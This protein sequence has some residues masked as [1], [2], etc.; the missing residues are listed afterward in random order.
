MGYC[1][2]LF[3]SLTIVNCHHAHPMQ[4]CFIAFQ[5]RNELGLG[6]FCS[7]TAVF[8]S[9]GF[10]FPGF[11]CFWI[12]F[13]LSSSYIQCSLCS[14]ALLYGYWQG[15]GTSMYFQLLEGNHGSCV[16]IRDMV[17]IHGV[18]ALFETAQLCASFCTKSGGELALLKSVW[19]AFRIC[20]K[21]CFRGTSDK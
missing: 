13:V 16:C 5:Q 1:I 7:H 9:P 14:E 20:R 4:S 18:E 2:Y 10:S 6:V 15:W 8:P 11:G 3:P 21:T 19:P 17:C 12:G